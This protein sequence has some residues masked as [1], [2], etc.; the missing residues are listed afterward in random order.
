MG[1]THPIP[2]QLSHPP[3]Y[4]KNYAANPQKCGMV[5]SGKRGP[6]VVVNLISSP[7]FVRMEGAAVR[8]QIVL[9]PEANGEPLASRVHRAVRRISS[10]LPRKFKVSGESSFS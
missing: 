3:G 1:A 5:C 9:F 7:I 2:F 8:Q 6:R 10:E 4:K